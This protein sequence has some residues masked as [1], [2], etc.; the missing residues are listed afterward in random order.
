MNK[1]TFNFTCICPSDKETISYKAIIETKEM[2]M[3]ENINDYI[4]QISGK[5]WFQEELTDI[6]ANKFSITGEGHGVKVTTFGTHQ[7]V[8]IECELG[9]STL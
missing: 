6:L 7:G 2:I 8:E 4:Y 9:S 5:E 1:Y 3:V